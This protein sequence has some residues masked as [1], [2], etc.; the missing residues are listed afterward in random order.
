MGNRREFMTATAAGLAAAAAAPARAAE[1]RTAAPKSTPTGA[2]PFG[3]PRDMVLLNLRRGD[4]DALG[5]K[6]KDGVLDV[7]AGRSG[8]RTPQTWTPF[9]PRGAAGPCAP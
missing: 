9:T 7:E 3:M 5:V 6:T 2:P 4:G 1:E 8:C